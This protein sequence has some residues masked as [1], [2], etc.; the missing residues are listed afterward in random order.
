LVLLNEAAM[1]NWKPILAPVL[2]FVLGAICGGGGVALYAMKQIVRMAEASPAET[3]ELSARALARRLNLDPQQRAAARPILLETAR[4]LAR[5]R[6]ESMP[7]VRAAINDAAAR[8]RP[9]LR[10]AQQEKLHQLL[11]RPRARWD[12]LAPERPPPQR[13]QRPDL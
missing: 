13:P 6:G 1:K 4:E 7:Q 8:L 9:I 2:V 12:R 10:P 11:A 3:S 5:I